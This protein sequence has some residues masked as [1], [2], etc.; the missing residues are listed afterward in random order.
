[1][2]KLYWLVGSSALLACLTALPQVASAQSIGVNIQMPNGWGGWNYH[3]NLYQTSENRAG[4]ELQD[5]WNQLNRQGADPDLDMTGAT[6][7]PLIDSTGAATATTVSVTGDF[8]YG[9]YNNVDNFAGIDPGSHELS[10]LESNQVRLYN[11]F[12]GYN[13]GNSGNVFSLS[14]IPYDTYDVVIYPSSSNG[15]TASVQLNGAGDTYYFE[16]VTS[17][18][19]KEQLS[20]W[21]EP[22]LVGTS[23]TPGEYSQANVIVFEGVTGSTLDVFHEAI[24]GNSGIGAIQIIGPEVPDLTLTLEVNT[25]NGEIMLSNNTAAPVG[26]A[27]LSIMSGG[28]SLLPGSW[29]SISDSYDEGAGGSISPD[30]W[31]EIEASS[32]ELAEGTLGS[33]GATLAAGE[34]ISLGNSWVQSPIEDLSFEYLLSGVNETITGAVSYSGS[35]GRLRPG[36][37]DGNG[38]IDASDWP[39]QRDNYGADLTGMTTVEAYLMGDMDFDGDNDLA[40]LRAFKAAY[41]AAGGSLSALSGASVPEPSTIMILS[42]AGAL[43][44][45]RRLRRAVRYAAPLLVA[46]VL[47]LAGTQAMALSIG[48]N[49]NSNSN[50]VFASTTL[51]GAVAQTNWNQSTPAAN[52][53]N[54]TISGLVDSFGTATSASVTFTAPNTW[55]QGGANTSDG[56]ISLLKG[57]LDDGGAGSNVQVTGVPYAEYDLYIYGIG[58]GAQGTIMEDFSVTAGGFS[59][60]PTWVR[61]ANVTAGGAL[62]EGGDGIEGH[63]VKLTG[64][65]SSDLTITG[66]RGATGRAPLAGFQIVD[67]SVATALTLRIDPETGIG[68]IMNSIGG[69]VDLDFYEIASGDSNS[70]TYSTWQSVQDTGNGGLPQG[71]GSGNGWE[72]LGNLG[73]DKLSEFFLDGQ[74]TLA[75]GASVSLGRIFDTSGGVQEDITFQYS[76]GSSLINGIVEFA[77]G[78]EGLPGDYN[79]DGSVDIADYTVWRNN[80]GAADESGLNGNGDGGG[81]TM[82]DY[83]YW[84]TNFSTNNAPSIGAASVP[85]PSTVLVALMGVAGA[86]VCGRRFNMAYCKPAVMFCLFAFVVSGIAR[87][88]YTNDRLYLFGEGTGENGSPGVVV[89]SGHNISGAGDTLDEVGVPSELPG[90]YLDL[91]QTGAPTYV[92]MTSGAYARS[93]ATAGGLGVL[94]DGVDDA[95]SG[96]ALNRPDE[97]AGQIDLIDGIEDGTP[98][99]PIDYTGITGRGL[100]MWVYP[101]ASAIGSSESPTT[102]QSIVSDTLSSGGPAINAQ[103]QWTQINS[104]H[105]G[106]PATVPVEGD[107]W[108]HVMHHNY[109]LSEPDE[110]NNVDALSVVYVDGKAV[111]ANFDV[112]FAGYNGDLVVGGHDTGEGYDNFFTG[113]VDNLEMYVFGDNET[114][115]PGNYGDGEDWGTFNYWTDNEWVADWMA[116]NHGSVVGGTPIV[117]DTDFDNDIDNDD[118]MALINGWRQGNLYQGAHGPS[119]AGDYLTWQ[120][121]DLN[122]DGV[123]NL[124]DWWIMRDV[125]PDGAN[126]NLAALMGGTSVPEPSS[127]LIVLGAGGL[128]AVLRKRAA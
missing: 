15:R 38:V 44:C 120:M 88:D 8:T 18:Y 90:A 17:Y 103:G 61:A 49:F 65:T 112:L 105:I 97:L 9:F 46:A 118:V 104:V 98:V 14:G 16:S 42:V 33:A 51:A 5:N 52:D 29:N 128:L 41:L 35:N 124:T 27:G 48:V 57:Y 123:V 69:P 63:Y 26:L 7:Y 34:S 74:S 84:K 25:D 87:A 64:L 82:S 114:G 72:E 67:P 56:N 2:K 40:D 92:S 125:H 43:V 91:V 126:L 53:I 85:E 19:A 79:N 45:G 113:A 122:F 36:D 99:Y 78:P 119:P 71:D 102:F 81:V 108:Y 31:Q 10:T 30:P 68:T 50:E 86:V 1:M 95:L 20:N 110:G 115:T 80:L 66:A 60:N 93:G 73:D 75:D 100:Q 39:T 21:D 47:L 107:T 121:G 4:Y 3:A 89:G 13:S 59:A 96:I 83:A 32:S 77:A 76:L 116:T 94:F 54:E 109:I 24:S 101:D 37:Y 6:A 127:L 11:G 117:G 23:T 58:D 70:L 28:A 111:S 22:W 55:A 106:V 62:I 12:I